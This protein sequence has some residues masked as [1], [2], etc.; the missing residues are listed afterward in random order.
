MTWKIH[1][2]SFI[3]QPKNELSHMTTI[4]HLYEIYLRHPGICTDTRKLCKGDL[5]F[6]LHGANFDGNDFALRALEQGAA[7]AVVDKD[8]APSDPRCLL[9][10]DT[11]TALQALAT[12]HRRQ[13]DIPVIGITGT[14]GKTTT[15]ELIRSVLSRKYNLLAT[16][17]NLNNHIGVPLMILRLDSSHEMALIEMGAGAPGEIHTLVEIAQPNVG[18]ITNIG[19]AHLQGFGSIEGVL[20]T[21]S[22]LPEYLYAHGGT[23]LLNSDDP[24]L[25]E[26]WGTQTV[27]TY[28]QEGN[29]VSG[30]V[31]GHLPYLSVS[32]GETVVHSQLVGAYNLINILAAIA[33]GKYF[34]VP[35]ADIY[36]GIEG[37]QPTN[38][39]SQLVRLEGGS[40]LIVDAYNA[41]PSSMA[42]AIDNL[43]DSPARH[44][45]AILGDMLELGEATEEEHR[46]VLIHLSAH[47]E[48]KALL[49]GPCF[50]KVAGEAFLAFEKVE[51]ICEYLCRHPLPSESLVL[52]KGS[53]GIALEKVLPLFCSGSL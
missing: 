44:K 36:A 31:A 2:F 6:A 1:R 28:G 12:H 13:F 16:E 37:Y 14:N 7:Y 15:K 27:L 4:Q 33:M 52:I 43:V 11:L 51:D 41:N 19:R 34:E 17:G 30:K 46:R 22:E 23:F 45:V 9:V 48:V 25:V 49:C 35:E 18:L 42:V 32:V 53:R 21:K 26:K 38:N 5:F 20:R 39:R 10:E 40:Q 3:H 50:R 29:Y 47:P 24:L 8:V